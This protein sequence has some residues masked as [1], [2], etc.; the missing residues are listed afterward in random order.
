MK[1]LYF[2][3]TLMRDH[4]DASAHCNPVMDKLLLLY[5]QHML[6]AVQLI[7][8]VEDP[9][10]EKLRLTRFETGFRRNFVVERLLKTTAFLMSG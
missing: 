1:L 8:D 5:L 9:E 3:A 4:R 2:C 6:P 7:M 10:S